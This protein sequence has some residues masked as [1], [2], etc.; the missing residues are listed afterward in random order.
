MLIKMT[1]LKGMGSAPYGYPEGPI[2]SY[3]GKDSEQCNHYCLLSIITIIIIISLSFYFFFGREDLVIHY[4]D[5][6][7]GG[8][9]GDGRLRK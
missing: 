9:G 7:F 3:T 1:H 6:G 8:G 5:K 2:I 4:F